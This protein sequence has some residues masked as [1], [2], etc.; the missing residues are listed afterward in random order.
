MINRDQKINLCPAIVYTNS[1]KN[2]RS[3]ISLSMPKKKKISVQKVDMTVDN[4][5]AVVAPPHRH[6]GL[7][8]M[9]VAV[10]AH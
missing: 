6:V 1:T 8:L 2:G 9:E 7:E 10:A 4:F 5:L 3:L